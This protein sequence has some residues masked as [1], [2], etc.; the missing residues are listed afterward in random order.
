[1]SAEDANLLADLIISF[2]NPV[3]EVEKEWRL[4]RV[5]LDTIKPENPRFR[6]HS[7]V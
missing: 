1:M 2:K 5:K 3:F 4:E 6:S 7:V